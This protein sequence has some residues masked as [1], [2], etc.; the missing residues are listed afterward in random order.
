MTE[1]RCPTT[2][3]SR[4]GYQHTCGRLLAQDLTEGKLT[5]KCPRCKTEVTVDRV[6]KPVV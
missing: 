6:P 4:T 5:I 2:L 3:T 1:V